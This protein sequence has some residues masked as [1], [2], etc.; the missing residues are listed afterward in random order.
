MN[1]KRN[2]IIFI[3]C[4]ILIIGIATF[5]FTIKFKGDNY[6]TDYEAI[7][8]VDKYGSIHVRETVV[9]KYSSYDN[10]F[11]RGIKFQKDVDG[12]I[13]NDGV[14]LSD[15][16]VGCYRGDLINDPDDAINISHRIDVA[17]SYSENN[18][19]ETE[20]GKKYLKSIDNE[21]FICIDAIN[22]GHLK[23]TMTYIYDYDISNMATIYDDCAELYYN[24]FDSENEYDINY[25]KVQITLPNKVDSLLGFSH[26]YKYV[27]KEETNQSITI[28]TND[29]KANTEYG[30]RIL[31]NKDVLTNNDVNYYSKN[32]YDSFILQEDELLASLE[33]SIKYIEI[34]DPILK[35]LGYLVIAAMAVITMIVY[36][37]YDKEYDIKYDGKISTPPYDYSPAIVG[38][39]INSEAV[40][41]SDV[42]ATLLDLL[43]RKVIYYKEDENND[44]VLW[45]DDEVFSLKSYENLVINFYFNVIGDGESVSLK[46]IE[47]YGKK[48]NSSQKLSDMFTNFQKEVI[49]AGESNNFYFDQ[50]K[51]KTKLMLFII[52][53]I[54]YLVFNIICK[55]LIGVDVVNHAIGIGII[56]IAYIIYIITFKKKTKE[57][58]IHY[59]KW[60]AYKEYLMNMKSIKNMDLTQIDYFDSVLV[61]AVTFN[62]ENKIMKELKVRE[63]HSYLVYHTLYYSNNHFYSNANFSS[64]GSTSSSGGG[65]GGGFSGGR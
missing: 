56:L 23:D 62:I 11:I 24:L 54:L 46:A 65:G 51:I 16:V 52:I 6:I 9:M 7:I 45:K 30:I 29:I 3:L 35:I 48:S 18:S 64:S 55:F 61:F 28:Y 63:D 15:V 43:R 53:P 27:Y 2:S 25:S 50:K 26:G 4:F 44:L 13:I 17:Y 57:G 38:Y 37:R 19:Y 12:N 20:H 14:A 60:L 1:N 40:N 49:K 47:E 10:Y 41:T 33:E 39:L 8:D 32:V 36:F 42:T 59:C 58:C 21:E 5:L 22:C 31:F 34:F